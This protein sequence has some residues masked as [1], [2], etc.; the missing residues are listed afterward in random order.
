MNSIVMP[1]PFLL[2][3][4]S[5][6]L[7]F[8]FPKPIFYTNLE[9][10]IQSGEMLSFYISE[11]TALE[12]YSVLGKYARGT[13]EQKV[14]CDRI[15]V[16]GQHKS[17]TNKYLSQQKRKKLKTKQVHD[18][19]KLIADIQSQRGNIQA[20]ILKLD[21]FS[22]E[23][24]TELLIKYADKYNFGSQDAMIAGTLIATKELKSL[25][26]TLVTSDKGLKAVLTEENLSFYDPK[27]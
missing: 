9:S 4:N 15:I 14:L 5:Y 7:I 23:K 11:I 22:I 6:Y 13:P 3:T 20:T 19:H 24:G 8:Q 2:D 25:D 16:N 21:S 10:K 18:L 27:I 12:I 26:L 1:T 17:C